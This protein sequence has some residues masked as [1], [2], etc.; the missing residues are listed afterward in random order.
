MSKTIK[1]LF[2]SSLVF[3]ILLIGFII[4]N[5]SHSLFR[6]DSPRIK[7]R[8]LAV[9]LP[10]EKEK[11]FLDTMEKVHLEN[12]KIRKQLREARER[13]FSILTAPQFDE[14]SYQ[15]EVEKLHELRGLMMQKLSNAT[16]ELAKQF[17][18]EERKALAEH[19]NR[20]PRPPRDSRPPDNE[21]PPLQ[22]KIPPDDRMP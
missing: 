3:N 13:I 20:S 14:A 11:F 19:L 15:S 2:L 18:Q 9:K 22:R 8:E 21:G 7:P 10:P 17:S 4:G 1:I 12:R 6:E 5:V 16:K